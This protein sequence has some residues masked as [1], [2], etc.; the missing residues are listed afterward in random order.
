MSINN[1]F[2]IAKTKEGLGETELNKKNSV[3]PKRRNELG[4]EFLES[5]NLLTAVAFDSGAGLLE[6]TAVDGAA[7]V[8]EVS[9]LDTD[10]LQLQLGNGAG[11]VLEDDALSNPDFELSTTVNTDDTLTINTQNVDI[12]DFSVD[13]GDLDDVF[14]IAGLVGVD[15]VTVLGGTGNDTISGAGADQ[16]L[17]LIGNQGNDILIGGSGDDLL[18]GGGGTDT[19][20]GGAGI[21]TNSFQGIGIGVEATVNADGTGT[22]VYGAVNESFVGIENLTGSENDDVLT[23]L[24]AAAN[25]LRGEGGDDILA[26]GGGTDVIDGG[27]GIDTNSFQN[28]GFGVT[29]TVNADGTGTAV[30]GAVNESFVSIENLTGS[31][32]DDVLIALGA[33]ANV[34]RLSLIHI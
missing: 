17:T 27:E 23:A 25:V 2:S 26:G 34:L 7:D 15:N 12:A 14:E 1:R 18:V 28:I 11:F 21:D 22:A 5:K 19:I 24:G 33:A 9:A 13:L 16:A 20:D 4:F 32:N 3:R 10:F 8:L 6:F 30:Y 29:A 31:E